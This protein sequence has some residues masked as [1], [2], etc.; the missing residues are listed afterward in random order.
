MILL[1]LVSGVLSTIGYLL[2]II[3]GL[4]LSVSW[5]FALPLVIDRNLPFWDAMELSRKV[6]AKH[7]FITFAFVLVMGLLA[8]CGVIACCVG[9]FVTMPIATVALMYAYEDIFGRQGP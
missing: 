4:Y 5:I 7:W 6:V 1:G 9:V 3:P 2:C 8:A